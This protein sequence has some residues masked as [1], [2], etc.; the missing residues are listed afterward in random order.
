MP[1]PN[2][3]GALHAAEA[4]EEVEVGFFS[5]KRFCQTP[6]SQQQVGAASQE[7]AAS[8]ALLEKLKKAII[9]AFGESPDDLIDLEAAQ[10]QIG[11]VAVY[12]FAKCHSLMPRNYLKEM[13]DRAILQLRIGICDQ[14]RAFFLHCCYHVPEER[15]QALCDKIVPFVQDAMQI[16]L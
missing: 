7:G 8:T 2:G 16:D 13:R 5:I 6:S 14:Q 15:A 12:A 11:H 9:P 4:E 10:E 3:E 1:K